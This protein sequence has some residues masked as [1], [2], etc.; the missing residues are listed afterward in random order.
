MGSSA[1]KSQEN[2]FERKL[3][4]EE[5]LRRNYKNLPERQKEVI[6]NSIKEQTQNKDSELWRDKYVRKSQHQ[7][8]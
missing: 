4:K 3:T 1:S 8:M 7:Y 5:E 6:E 2:Q